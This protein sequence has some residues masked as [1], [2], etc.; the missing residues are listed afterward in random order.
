MKKED[1]SKIAKA[2]GASRVVEVG[3]KTIGGPLDLLALRTEFNQRLRSSGGR[4]T[5]PSWTVTRLVP[6]KE[7]S[8]TRL[9]D[10][11]S[12]IGVSG[13]RVG[14]AQVA[15]LL[16]ES[17]LEEL[18]EVQWQEALEATRSSPLLSQPKAA[19]AAQ[20]TYN[21]FDDWVL[22]G[23]IVPAGRRGHERSYGSDEIIRAHWLRS[24]FQTNADLEALAPAVRACDLSARYLVVTDTEMVSTAPTRSQLYR[25]L[26]APGSHL[27]IDQLPERRKLL[28]L[29]LYP[30]DP[31]DE[32]RNRH[33]V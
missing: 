2:L 25:L 27:V 15:A 20:V 32:L 16:I 24:I 14:P 28:G 18:E 5:D 30:G 1:K 3:P 8:W 10:L 23:W 9:Q 7:D 26:E 6:F 11:A 12:E 21:Q 29:P 17:S 31:H 13:R 33:A 19:E 4:P 22:R